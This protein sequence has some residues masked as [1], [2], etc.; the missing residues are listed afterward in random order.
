MSENLYRS[1]VTDIRASQ[2]TV[3][4]RYVLESFELYLAIYS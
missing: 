1:G 3:C 4:E 2:T